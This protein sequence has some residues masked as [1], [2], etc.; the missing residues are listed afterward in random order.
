MVYARER[1]GL[2]LVCPKP[3]GPGPTGLEPMGPGPV[4]PEPISVMFWNETLKEFWT[5]EWRKIELHW[6]RLELLCRAERRW[7]RLERRLLAR[8]ALPALEKTRA[9]TE[10][11]SFGLL[12]GRLCRRS[13]ANDDC[14]PSTARLG[15]LR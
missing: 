7:L 3:V 6:S 8:R 13:Q 12:C 11:P 10:R 15:D 2:E 14:L 5:F 4:G 9:A 1:M